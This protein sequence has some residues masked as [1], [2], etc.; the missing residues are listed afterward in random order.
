MGIS[1]PYTWNIFI[2]QNIHW[3]TGHLILFDDFSYLSLDNLQFNVLL[4]E[5]LLVDK[6]YPL[7]DVNTSSFF[8]VILLSN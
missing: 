3:Q 6:I 4:S 8:N 7:L 2:V 5:S 1:P